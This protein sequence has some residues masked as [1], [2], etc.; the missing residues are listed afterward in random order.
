[1]R[2]YVRHPE[3]VAMPHPRPN[4][5]SKLD[6]FKEQIQQWMSQDHCYNFEEMKPGITCL[7]LLVLAA[8]DIRPK[9]SPFSEDGCPR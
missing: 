5:C 9:N 6:P 3:L 2:K 7:K 8:W 4:R 1:V